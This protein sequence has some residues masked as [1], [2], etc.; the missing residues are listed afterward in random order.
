MNKN[1]DSE[2]INDALSSFIP[3]TN[4]VEDEEQLHKLATKHLSS[5]FS[6]PNLL[7]IAATSYNSVKSIHKFS[8]LDEGTRGDDFALL[9]PDKLYKEAT[10]SATVATIKKSASFAPRFYKTDTLAETMP[11][12]R[13]KASWFGDVE[14]LQTPRAPFTKL[15]A[16]LE[17]S[18]QVEC[19]PAVIQKVANRVHNL[20]MDRKKKIRTFC[21]SMYN[22][23]KE[24]RDRVANYVTKKYDERGCDLVSKFNDD[25]PMYKVAT[26]STLGS[27]NYTPKG[28][29]Y[30][31]AQD[32]LLANESYNLAKDLKK[33]ASADLAELCN[34]V[35]GNYVMFKK[36]SGTTAFLSGGLLASAIPQVTGVDTT[37]KADI[38]TEMYSNKLK[39][40]I[41]KLEASRT[42]YEVL[43]DD[44]IASYPVPEVIAAYNNALQMMPRSEREHPASNI[45]L[46]RSWTAEILGRGGAPSAS[47]AQKVLDSSKAL[48]GNAKLQTNPYTTMV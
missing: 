20:D 3:M 43:S 36:A 24:A 42:M 33:Q 41:Q 10:N 37:S 13:K 11:Q 46:L 34:K 32:A 47:D 25:F 19:I 27:A 6:N 39:N 30:T 28:D 29:V 40:S 16:S 2:I 44:F 48:A 18:K 5:K 22:L 26:H 4:G 35:A 31:Q 7:K 12:L 1:K 21:N 45:Q 23:P 17:V 8:T 38:Y 9:D 15:G 14:Y